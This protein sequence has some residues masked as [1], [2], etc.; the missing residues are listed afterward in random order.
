MTSLLNSVEQFEHIGRIRGIGELKSRTK[1]RIKSCVEA[2]FF[3]PNLDFVN[4]LARIL[5]P[6]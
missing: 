4:G 1:L 6:T 3:R 5:S 2:G